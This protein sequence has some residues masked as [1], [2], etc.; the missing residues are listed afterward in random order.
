MLTFFTE[1]NRASISLLYYPPFLYP[2]KKAGCWLREE[3]GPDWSDVWINDLRSCFRWCRLL[4]ETELSTTDRRQAS[5]TQ[6]PLFWQHLHDPR[7][8]NW[9]YFQNTFKLELRT[10][11]QDACLSTMWVARF[12]NPLPQVFC[13]V[14]DCPA[15]EKNATFMPRRVS[16]A[17]PSESCFSIAS[18]WYME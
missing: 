17:E 3:G 14:G 11:V 15:L 4:W 9:N 7:C 16:M 18:A 6:C 5:V 10:E 12:E 2:S 8:T 13:C 1:K